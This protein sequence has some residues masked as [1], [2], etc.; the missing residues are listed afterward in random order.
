MFHG[1]H[2]VNREYFTENMARFKKNLY[3]IYAM[4]INAFWHR[5]K[6]LIR[7]KAVTQDI[8]AKAVGLSPNTFRAWMSKGRIPPLSCAYK[9]AR[10]FNVSLEFLIDGKVAR[11]TSKITNEE[12]LVLLKPAENLI[13]NF[14]SFLQ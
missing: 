11:K 9:F 6:I 4:K 5:I 7:E 3:I 12:I 14:I 8:V 2:K 1:G 13:W 10:Y